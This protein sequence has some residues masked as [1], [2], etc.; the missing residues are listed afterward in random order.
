MPKEILEITPSGGIYCLVDLKKSVTIPP[1]FNCAKPNGYAIQDILNEN[2]FSD[3]DMPDGFFTDGDILRWAF[4]YICESS[5]GRALVHDARFDGWMIMIQDGDDLSDKAIADLD[6]KCL[7]ISRYSESVATFSRNAQAQMEFI[8]QM[9]K[10]LRR[11][12]QENS[13][14]VETDKLEPSEYLK[15]ERLIDADGDICALLT[16]YQLREKGDHDVWRHVLS[17]DLHKLGTTMAECLDF[18][19]SPDGVLDTMGFIFQDWFNEDS[20]LNKI[21]ALSLSDL[22]VRADFGFAHEDIG[23]E[24]FLKLSTLPDGF[25]YLEYAAAEILGDAFYARMPDDINAAHLKQISRE[26][27]INLVEEIGFRDIN[28]ARKFFPNSTFETVV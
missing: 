19:A 11:I 25:S 27:Q 8:L 5:L 18:D 17:S 16:A 15:Y 14:F 4:S 28:L 9:I 6:D 23:F 22:D 3:E 7:Y 20:R 1:V 10:G 13:A 26:S 2:R 12:W 24:N 21:D